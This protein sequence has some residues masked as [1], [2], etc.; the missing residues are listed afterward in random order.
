MNK[1]MKDFLK[2]NSK[3]KSVA[4]LSLIS[5]TTL[6]MIFPV[7]AI[8]VSS[9]QYHTVYAAS[10]SSSSSKGGSSSA[11]NST[12]SIGSST[13]LKVTTKV[14]NSKGGTSKPSDFTITV[15][16]KSP[17]PGKRLVAFLRSNVS[18]QQWI[19][20][21]KGILRPGDLARIN[22]DKWVSGPN[23]KP[24]NA[25][26]PDQISPGLIK[27]AEYTSAAG[28]AANVGKVKAVGGKAIGFDFESG[29]GFGTPQDL[30]NPLAAIASAS[31]AAHQAG[32]LFT[33]ALDRAL[34]MKLGA[35]VAKFCDVV[36]YQGQGLVIASPNATGIQQYANYVIPLAQQSRQINPNVRVISQVGTR[37]GSLAIMQQATTAVISYVDFISVWPD[38]KISGWDSMLRQFGTW[39]RAHY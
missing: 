38:T 10:S 9:Y 1:A 7:T 24:L 26:L 34:G 19:S 2:E 29:A 35:Q 36:N 8:F 14:D 28:V 15:S 6:L 22:P 30:A 11:S 4:K 17:S 13:F 32:L 27:F 23:P 37:I 12:S 31:Q 25:N 39:F 18:D 3:Y 5:V 33:L 20:I 16:G 21:W